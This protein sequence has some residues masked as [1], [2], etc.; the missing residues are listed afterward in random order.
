MAD[1]QQVEGWKACGCPDCRL[2]L[3]NARLRDLLQ[4]FVDADLCTQSL[5][6]I[7][8]DEALRLHQEAKAALAGEAPNA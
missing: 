3:E 8:L 7:S 2:R 5:P 4:R 6:K 1:V